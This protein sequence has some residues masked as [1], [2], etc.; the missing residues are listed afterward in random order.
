MESLLNSGINGNID[1]DKK[2]ARLT[3][4]EFDKQSICKI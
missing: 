4:N 1:H 2:Q 3:Y